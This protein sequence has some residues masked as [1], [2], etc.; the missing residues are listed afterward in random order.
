ME[1]FNALLNVLSWRHAVHQFTNQISTEQIQNLLE[2]TGLVAT[3]YGLQSFRIL[4]RASDSIRQQL[5]EHSYRQASR[6][7]FVMTTDDQDMRLEV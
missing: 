6:R 3:F 5:A 7:K 2:A 1:L 4:V